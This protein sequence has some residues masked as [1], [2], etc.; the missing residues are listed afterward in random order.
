[1]RFRFILFALLFLIQA[2]KSQSACEFEFLKDTLTIPEE[3]KILEGLSLETTLKNLSVIKIFQSNDQ[4][5]D[6]LYL[7]I[8]VTKNFYFNKVDKL[9]LRSG[10]KSYWVKP[11]SKQYKVSKTMGLFVVRVAKNYIVTLKEEGITSLVF[12][13]AETDFT[14]TD[15]QQIKKISR[16]FYETIYRKK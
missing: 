6:H 9:E 11:D 15:A 2:F 13:G 10:S 1:M 3:G 14:K 7:R 12:S 8:L 16:C 4:K 5:D